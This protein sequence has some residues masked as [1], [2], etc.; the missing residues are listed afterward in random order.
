MT[1]ATLIHSPTRRR[2]NPWLPARTTQPTRRLIPV[3]ALL[4]GGAQVGALRAP[5]LSR[6]H[7]TALGGYFLFICISGNECM[8]MLRNTN[9]ADPCGVFVITKSGKISCPTV[10]NS[11]FNSVL[12]V[13]PCWLV[14]LLWPKAPCWLRPMPKLG[15]WVTKL[16][17]P[18]LT[19]KNTPSTP[20][21]S[22]V[23]TAPCT[24]AR[25]LMQQADAHCSLA[26]KW[27]ARAGAA[28]TPKRPDSFGWHRALMA[29]C[30]SAA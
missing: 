7:P 6:H 10:A 24:K 19:P 17:Q 2:I 9:C 14:T 12:V 21:A 20:P 15:H 28:L 13:L 30:A 4:T 27:L 1:A 26:S 11:L 22:C 23:T 3:V 8:T 25:P 18:K 16:T 29:P 5:R